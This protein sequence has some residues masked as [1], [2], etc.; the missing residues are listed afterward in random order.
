LFTSSNNLNK[1]DL[2][3]LALTISIN[4]SF[5]CTIYRTMKN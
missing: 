2:A 5:N 4:Q 1:L 3:S